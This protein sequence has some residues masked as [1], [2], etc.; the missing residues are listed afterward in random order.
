VRAQI[1]I[2]MNGDLGPRKEKDL[3]KVLLAHPMV[4]AVHRVSGEDCFVAQ[5]VCRRIEDVNAL[6][7][8]LQSTRALAHSRTAFVLETVVE[9]GSFGSVEGLV[10]D[11][12]EP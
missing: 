10:A 4:R 12:E 5:V 6:L 1:R 3:V 8:Q 11:E 7:G 2:A 9:K